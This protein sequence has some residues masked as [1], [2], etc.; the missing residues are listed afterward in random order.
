M[1]NGPQQAKANH[2]AGHDRHER[3]K[4]ERSLDLIEVRAPDGHIAVH[5]NCREW[6]R[7]RDGFLRII[8]RS[9]RLLAEYAPRGWTDVH[10]R[11]LKYLEEDP[12]GEETQR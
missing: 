12:H 9:G 6:K 3:P 10:W 8:G 4:G 7:S 5:Q 1:L 2:P 11:S